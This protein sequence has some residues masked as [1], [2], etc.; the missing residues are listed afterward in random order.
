MQFLIALW[1]GHIYFSRVFVGLIQSFQ[2]KS[3]KWNSLCWPNESCYVLKWLLYELY[4]IHRYTIDSRRVLCCPWDKHNNLKYYKILLGHLFAFYF[5]NITK[6]F[7]YK[8]SDRIW[9]QWQI[10]MGCMYLVSES[11]S[12]MYYT[13]RCWSYL[14]CSHC[15]RGHIRRDLQPG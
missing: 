8:G 1:F 13:H 4:F 2:W 7:Y 10:I 11:W 9:H 5:C 14:S 15:T 12:E 3:L 6:T